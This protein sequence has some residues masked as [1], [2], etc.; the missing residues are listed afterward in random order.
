METMNY[1]RNGKWVG[2]ALREAREA[3]YSNK[4]RNLKEGIEWLKAN[5]DR[6]LPETI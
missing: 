4:F 2:K 3:Q 5:R 1:S 6:L